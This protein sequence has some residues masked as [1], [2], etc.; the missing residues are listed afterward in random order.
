[1]AEPVEEL[2][3]LVGVPAHV[4]RLGELADELAEARAELVCEVRRRGADER[5]DVVAGWLAHRPRGY[6]YGQ[7]VRR[8]S[9]VDLMLLGTVVL[10]AL[11]I[12]VTKYVLESGFKPLAY[13]TTRYFAATSLFWAFTYAR[14]RSF[15][16]SWRDSRLIAAAAALIFVNQLCFVY[17]IDLTTASTVALVLGITPIFIGILATLLGLE[18]LSRT[19]W[20]A[21]AIS[22]VGVGLVAAGAGGG[23]STDILGDVLAVATA[24]TWG[25]YSVAI[26]PLMRRYSPF[27]ISALVLALGWVPLAVVGFHQATR[28]EFA[29]GWKTWLAFAYAVIGPLFMTNILWFTAIARVGPSRASLFANL[30]PFFAVVFALLLLSEHL[31]RWQVAGGFAIAAGIVL[32]RARR[33]LAAAPVPAE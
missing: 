6:S 25:A 10:W 21:A 27:R 1:V 31:N 29:F 19:F 14:E 3:L 15:A 8:A 5:V 22:F 2:H 26:A 20:A 24:A 12:T 18:R 7:E 11:N 13:A 33:P 17:S 30:Q 16:V 4:V 23:F 32:E 9:A 28:Q